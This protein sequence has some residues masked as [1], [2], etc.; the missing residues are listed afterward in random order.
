MENPKKKTKNTKKSKVVES[1]TPRR[2]KL[3]AGNGSVICPKQNCGCVRNTVVYY[4]PSDG[5]GGHTKAI[6][7]CGECGIPV[8][9]EVD[10]YLTPEP[11]GLIADREVRVRGH[12]GGR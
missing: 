9:V 8:G 4:P 3:V 10:L 7:E 2:F 1:I 12:D 6:L 5:V 11:P